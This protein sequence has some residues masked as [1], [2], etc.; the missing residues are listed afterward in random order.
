MNETIEPTICPNCKQI[1]TKRICFNSYACV[2]ATRR[3]TE[4]QVA[5]LS[6]RGY[7]D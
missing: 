7:Y 5:Y 3:D 6:A 2:D 4:K 1:R